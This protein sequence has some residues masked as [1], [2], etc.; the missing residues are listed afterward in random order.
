M[1]VHCLKACLPL[2]SCACKKRE[3]ACAWELFSV[4]AVQPCRLLTPHAVRRLVKGMGKKGPSELQGRARQLVEAWMKL[5]DG[6]AMQKKLAPD[7]K[8]R[9]APLQ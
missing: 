8:K 4:C 5:L 9:W 2:S 1:S 6:P 3:L 7:Q